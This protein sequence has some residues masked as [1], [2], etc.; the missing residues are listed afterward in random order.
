MERFITNCEK[1]I[2][3]CYGCPV[4]GVA[5]EMLVANGTEPVNKL[6]MIV[7]KDHCP[8]GKS[9]TIDGDPHKLAIKHVRLS[10]NTEISGAEAAGL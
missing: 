4:V 2:N 9:P 6:L 7:A 8:S 1:G 10:R 3:S 5:A